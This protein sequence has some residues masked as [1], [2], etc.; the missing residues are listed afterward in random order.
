ML[1]ITQ[2]K[3]NSKYILIIVIL[4]A[5]VGGASLFYGWQIKKQTVNP[6]NNSVVQKTEEPMDTTDWQTYQNKAFGFELRYPKGWELKEEAAR[7]YLFAFPCQT[8]CSVESSDISLAMIDNKELL[9]AKDWLKQNAS[10]T[11]Q[12]TN[13]TFSNNGASG[14]KRIY[15]DINNSPVAV[16]VVWPHQDKMYYLVA[17][18][19]E[20]IKVAGQML[21]ELHFF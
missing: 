5:L 8:N 2:G 10:S 3:T 18:G 11:D 19:Q 6:P 7:V 14:I 17:I 16:I 4:A 21:L 9:S 1:F 13:E 20:N 12:E 15:K